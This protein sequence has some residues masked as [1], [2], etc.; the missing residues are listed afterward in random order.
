MRRTWLALL[1]GVAIGALA[2]APGHS[3]PSVLGSTAVSWEEIQALPSGTGTTHAK[4]VF[5]S[6]TATLDE[7]E[8]HVSTLPVGQSPHAPHKHPDEELIII[9]E[10]TVEVM[11]GG[12]TK[13]VG[14]GSVILQA[15]NQLHGM[16]NV[17]NVPAVYHVIRWNSPGMLE[18]NKAA[19]K[20]D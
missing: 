3:A 14:P 8:L 15:S 9:K 11:V 19:A 18:K 13:R 2:S 7:L 5:K 4:Q 20:A 12:V 6:P 17:G 10:G 1:A 16:T